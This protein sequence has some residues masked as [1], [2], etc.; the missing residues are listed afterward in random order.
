[1]NAWLARLLGYGSDESIRDVGVTWAAPWVQAAPLTVVAA[2]L[3]AAAIGVWFYRRSPGIKRPV[4]RGTLAGIRAALLVLLV[5]YLAEP[6]LEFRVS[7]HPKPW[8]WLLFDGSQS[9]TIEDEQPAE[10]GADVDPQRAV[11]PELPGDPG[12]VGRRRQEQGRHH[13]GATDQ[14]PRRDEG[15][16]R[17]QSP[18]GRGQG[19]HRCTSP[20]RAIVASSTGRRTK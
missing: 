16:E 2:V 11:S 6:T 18:D 17:H 14:A 13:A 4:V 15:H 9:M 7:V 5:L 8:L 1:M 20:H 12:H 19:P 10:A 3:V